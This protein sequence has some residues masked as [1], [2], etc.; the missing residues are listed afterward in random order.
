[1]RAEGRGKPEALPRSALGPRTAL[2]SSQHALQRCLEVLR[3]E[4]ERAGG[5]LVGNAA[6]RV[7]DVEAVGPARGRALDAVV[8]LVDD[9][10]EVDAEAEHAGASGSGSLV[11]RL[12]A[13]HEHVL[14]DVHPHLP[15][16]DR[17][18]L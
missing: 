9:G 5:T 7:D 10:R 16:V 6:V 11:E 3:L 13:R 14:A 17:M 12:R 18:R 1:M 2:P 8:G 4:A 15:E